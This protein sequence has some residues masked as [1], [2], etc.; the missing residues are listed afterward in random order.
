MRSSGCQP[1][2]RRQPSLSASPSLA[3]PSTLSPVTARTSGLD[4][5]SATQPLRN[6]PGTRGSSSS[7]VPSRATSDRPS[8]HWSVALVVPVEELWSN[9]EG[10]ELANRCDTH[11]Q[12]VTIAARQGANRLRSQRSLLLGF[13]RHT[14]LQL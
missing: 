4:S 12:M 2:R 1:A 13:L 3:L 9:L 6:T 7:P 8:E 11:L 5:W 10:R 14:G